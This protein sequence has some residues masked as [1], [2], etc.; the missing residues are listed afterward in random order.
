MKIGIMTFWWSEYNYG[1]LLQCYA[2]QKY[3]KDMGHDAFL[4]RY[5]PRNDLRKT[6]IYIKLLKA[7]SP[8][9]LSK[10]IRNKI[11]HHK[12]ITEQKQNPRNF[13]SFRNTYIKQSEKLYTSY[14]QLKEDPPDADV[15]IVG[16]DQVWNFGNL[17]VSKVKNLIDAYFLNFGSE[18]TKRLSYAAS[19]GQVSI[20][21]EYIKIIKPLLEKFDYVS[22]REK[23]GVE[24]CNNCDVD[25][26][27]VPDPTMLL[28]ADKYRDIYNENNFEKPKKVFVLL[29]LLGNECDF[30]IKKFY[31][32]AKNKDIEVIYV[33]GNN[34]IDKYQKTFATIPQWLYLVDNAEYVVTN[35]YH[36]CVFSAIFNK[37]FAAVPV[38]GNIKGM[39]SRLDSLW[40]LLH[41][42]PRVIK[43]DNF[44]I[45]G[46]K[47]DNKGIN[48]R[49][50]HNIQILK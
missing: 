17:N 23:T 7:L 15:Y 45:I 24:L 6:K 40:E 31:D 12:S 5:D 30:S 39:N 42:E 19:W 35:S 41:I 37:Q 1:Q 18:K 4:I 38:K 43:D 44:D 25:A 20:S 22:V 48:E 46:K 32:W 14:N 3:L 33:T 28:M 50:Q 29:Y 8:I 34:N 49:K 11:R 10:Y 36:C 21:Q 2:L 47:Y 26:E 27:W 16:S 9:R 13:D